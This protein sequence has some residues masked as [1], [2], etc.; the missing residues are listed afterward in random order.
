MRK[1][2][3]GIDEA[4]VVSNSGERRERERG[5]KRGRKEGGREGE[6]EREGAEGGRERDGGEREGEREIQLHVDITSNKIAGAM[7]PVQKI[8]ALP[9]IVNHKRRTTRLHLTND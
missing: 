6:G 2:P 4:R 7:T 9:R 8:I 3:L 5:G 1:L